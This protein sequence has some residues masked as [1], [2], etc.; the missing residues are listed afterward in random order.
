VRIKKVLDLDSIEKYGF[1]VGDR[2]R[3]K[4]NRKRKGF[5]IGFRDNGTIIVTFGYNQT[6][7]SKDMIELDKRDNELTIQVYQLKS[8]LKR[9]T[10]LYPYL[11]MEEEKG[12]NVP[13]KEVV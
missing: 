13:K 5:V 9:I 12:E 10:K 8:L 3:V 4:D 6:D 7:L 1:R 2:I 11:H